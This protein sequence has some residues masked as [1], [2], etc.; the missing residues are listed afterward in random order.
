MSPNWYSENG[1]KTFNGTDYFLAGTYKTKEEAKTHQKNFKG[2]HWGSRVSKEEI[3]H[4]TPKTRYI[5]WVRTI[6]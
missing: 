6:H 4:E 5:L 2:R 1:K 3:P